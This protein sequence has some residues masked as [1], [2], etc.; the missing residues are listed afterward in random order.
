MNKKVVVV[1]VLI[2]VAFIAGLSYFFSTKDIEKTDLTK[3]KFAM[4]P[5]ADHTYAIIG[6]EKGWFKEVG[7]DV[8]Y[9]TIKIDEIIPYFTNNQYDIISCPPGILFSSYET[10]PNLVSFVFG[11]LFQG[12]AILAQPEGKY[13]SFDDIISKNNISPDSALIL[14]ANQLRGKTFTYPSET[15][16]RPFID[17]ILN[18]GRIKSS[19]FKPL[20]LEDALTINA[21]RND[22]AD[23]QV[24]GVP[25]R[26]VLQSEGYK[27]IISSIDIVKTANPSTNSKELASILQNGWA[28]TK[29]FYESNINTLLRLASVNYRIMDF[30][31]NDTEQALEIHMKYLSKVT[32]EKFDTL[33][34]RV[35]YQDLNPFYTFNQQYD[36]FYNDTSLLYYKY[37]NGSIL[38][39]FIE[40]N[41]YKKKIPSV[42]EVIYSDDIYKML[43][44]LKIESDSLFGVIDSN[45]ELKKNDLYEKAKRNYQIYNFLDSK[46]MCEKIIKE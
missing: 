34:G 43:Y 41:V 29:E 24:G 23:F 27:P 37:V 44:N 33:N 31:N 42:E 26:I 1:A 5:Y 32:G 6:I 36:W 22:D 20:I 10:A 7:I 13:L 8:E 17:L 46:L 28:T 21:M 45:S 38:N 15:A 9:Q 3:I 18:K 2:I 11:D 19:D 30:I 12:Y 14:A 16:I 35:I 39:S 4:L 40:S 25:A